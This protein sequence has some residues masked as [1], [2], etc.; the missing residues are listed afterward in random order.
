MSA[1]YR[2]L[3]TLDF[4]P[5]TLVLTGLALY[6]GVALLS[7]KFT[8][9]WL[10]LAAIALPGLIY[11]GL[12]SFQAPFL[13]LLAV[14]VGSYMGNMLQMV[15]GENIPFSLFQFFYIL[16]LG[17]F[18]LGRTASANFR[19]YVTGIELEILLFFTIVFLHATYTPDPEFALLF[20]GRMVFLSLLVYLI[21]NSIQS[22]RQVAILFIAMIAVAVLL[23]ILSVRDG[24]LNPEAAAFRFVM[25]HADRIITR[26]RVA[27]N[28][29]NVF[30]TFFFLPI[31][32][33]ACLLVS[34]ISKKLK[35]AS[36][37]VLL[38][39]ML[40]LLST[41]SR[42]ALVSVVGMLVLIGLIYR[43][44]K[45]FALF[46]V[47]FIGA[48]IVVPALR[49]IFADVFMRVLSL[50]T[51]DVDDSN[52]IRLI[53]LSWSFRSFFENYMIGQGF[54][55]FRH[56]FSS[57]YDRFET[58]GVTDSHNEIGTILV[59]MGL[60]GLFFFSV[61]VFRILY[62]AW[63]NIGRS[64]TPLQKALSV[65]VFST[66][67]GF[68]AFYQF[69]G[70]ALVDNNLWMLVGFTFILQILF[71]KQEEASNVQARS[72]DSGP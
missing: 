42:S 7:L 48:I 22:F 39:M 56:E 51:G 57:D 53:L 19:L 45:L 63:Q 66:L 64:R 9:F 23:A 47:L 1:L 58:I 70:G 67:V 13:M 27:H 18:L 3:V 49:E 28:D 6:L 35:L 60:I 5:H 31:S 40:G 26:G 44:Y 52:R 46:F 32:F 8:I 69:I 12:K 34:D 14:V 11:L 10:P 59:E 21:L 43:Q 24:L 62:N 72:K 20:A 25:G 68:V 29:P 16:A 55:S 50:I 17:V 61:L 4:G 36:A 38:I 65:S 15:A 71:Q 33:L 41:F 54:G 30:A 2:R 37:V